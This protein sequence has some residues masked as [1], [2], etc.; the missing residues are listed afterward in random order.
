MPNLH[1]AMF[2]PFLS[3]RP[4][5]PNLMVIRGISKFFAA[6]GLRLGYGVSSNAEFLAHLKKVQNPWSVSSIAA[7]AGEHLFAETEFIVKTKVLH[8]PPAHP[9]DTRTFRNFQAVCLSKR[10]QLSVCRDPGFRLYIV[11]II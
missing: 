4:E 2:L 1:V 3:S 11:R 10:Q 7:F 8:I 5:F 9:H 6:P